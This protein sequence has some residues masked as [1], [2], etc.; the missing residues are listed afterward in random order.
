MNLSSYFF[1]IEERHVA[2]HNGQ[3]DE[4]NFENPLSSSYKAIVRADTNETISIVR[5]SYKIVENEELV[6]KLMYELIHLD[7][8]FKLD[9]SHSFV[10]NNRMR[11][12]VT[13]PDLTIADS[14]SSIALSLF[15]SN[16]YDMSEG[17]RLYFGA[18]RAICSNGMVFG[19]ILS[20]FYGRHTKNLEITNVADN[21]RTAID[22]L[23]AIQNRIRELEFSPVTPKLVESVE[24]NIG[25]TIAKQVF[26]DDQP[27]S[28]WQ[29]YNRITHIV[30]HDLDQP[31]RARYQQ[32]VAKVFE[33]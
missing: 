31:L 21:L 28:A 9:Q 25:K 18:I 32:N 14:E 27:L 3:S 13:F 19:Q 5:D 20:R 10:Q 15:L 12:Q 24:Q 23:P 30:S 1:P 29:A 7:S 4:S 22:H 33:L 2:V 8:P 17:V 11:L 26:V 16:S 6:N